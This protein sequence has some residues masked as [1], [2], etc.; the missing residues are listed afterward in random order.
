MSRYVVNLTWD[1]APHLAQAEKDELWQSIPPYQRQART[2]GIPFLGSGVIY[3]FAEERLKVDPFVLPR[4]WPRCFGLDS[5]AGAGFTA[6]VWLAWDRENSTVYL[7]HAYKSDSRSKADHVEALKAKGTSRNPL[8]IPGVG[9]AKGLVVTEQDSAQVMELYRK[10]GVPIHF[11]DKSVEAGIQDVY[12]QMNV[13]KFKVFASCTE[14]F[15][16]FRQYHRKDGKIVKVN[17]HL[18]DATRYG[19][20]SGL[21]HARTAPLE[22]DPE[23]K[24]M[25][26]DMGQQGTGWLGM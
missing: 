12:D 21:G 2:K 17:D 19:L 26:Y 24:V 8:W 16:E 5:D 7:T 18:M 1:D 14:W 23:P 20:R 15:T 13:G 11:P 6:I 25:V 3:P 9:D 10:A 4:E 22:K